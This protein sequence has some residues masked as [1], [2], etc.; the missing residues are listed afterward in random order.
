MK[1]IVEIFNDGKEESQSFEASLDEETRYSLTLVTYGE[2]EEEAVS[3]LKERVQE[4]ILQLQSID[5]TKK[6]Q[7]IDF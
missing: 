3:N 2:S 5:W 7:R 1:T 4:L 6:R